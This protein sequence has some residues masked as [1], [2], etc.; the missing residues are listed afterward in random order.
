[1]ELAGAAPVLP[2]VFARFETLDRSYQ[3]IDSVKARAENFAVVEPARLFV[4]ANRPQTELT[5]LIATK[6][7]QYRSREPRYFGICIGFGWFLTSF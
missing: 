7:V 3:P 5:G 6:I 1:M 2:A 4:A